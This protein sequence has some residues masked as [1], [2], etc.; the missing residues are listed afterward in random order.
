VEQDVKKL[1]IRGHPALALDDSL[2]GAGVGRLRE[3]FIAARI[4]VGLACVG[5]I[6]FIIV[7][8]PIQKRNEGGPER[9]SAIGFGIGGIGLEFC[10]T[11]RRNALGL[12]FVT[13][14]ERLSYAV[15][16]LQFRLCRFAGRSGCVLVRATT[17]QK[18]KN[19]SNPPF[20]HLICL[21]H[22]NALKVYRT[23]LAP[24]NKKEGLVCCGKS[25]IKDVLV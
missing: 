10:A 6:V 25:G 11:Q 18:N 20:T 24:G 5:I 1:L 3:K 12:G 16:L 15:A 13:G 23:I 22:F 8:D 19:K 21:G 14:L 2:H 17:N 7:A 4:G 9:A